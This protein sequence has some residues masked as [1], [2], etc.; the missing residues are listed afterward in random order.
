VPD[1][2]V[3]PGVA[4][5]W[6]MT[7]GEPVVRI[8]IVDGPA[9]LA[10]PALHGAAIKVLPPTWLPR[11]LQPM[12]GFPDL[13][14][15]RREHGT[16]VASVLFGRH[17]SEVPGLVPGCSGV[18]VPSLRGDAN[19]LDALNLARAI[20]AAVDAGA[21]VV[22]VELCVPSAS[23]DVDRVLRRSLEA[24]RR[25][26]VLIVAAAGNEHSRH[27]CFPA[28]VPEV[29]AVGA[30]DDDG[31][32]YRFS[33]WGPQYA[34]HGLVAPGGNMT[35]AVPGGATKVHKGT[36]CST[37][38]VAGVAGLLLSLQA[39]HGA[40]PD[41]P[42]VGRALL[43]SAAP[44]S[45]RTGD[46]Q[47]ERCMAG[48]LDVAAATELVLDGLRAGG[49][50]RSR[51]AG[52][53]RVT[54]STIAGRRIAA[55]GSAPVFALATL[56][57][58]FG[59]QARRD[60]FERFMAVSATPGAVHDER[61][62]H[63]HLLAYPSDA[64]AL[65][66]TLRLDKE[67]IYALEPAGPYAPAIYEQIVRLLGEQHAGRAERTSVAGRL[68]SGRAELLTGERGG[69]D[70]L[71]AAVADFLTRI[72]VELANR[73]RTAAQRALNFSATNAYQAADT[74]GAALA[75]GLV[76]DGIDAERSPFARADS[77]CWDVRLSFFDPENG[78]RAR[79]TTRFTIDVSDVMPVTLGEVRAWSE[80]R[81]A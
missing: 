75:R 13:A 77:D 67:P 24:A 27:S 26:G 72:H 40:R 41:P 1:V 5:L 2:G 79:R 36:S 45:V 4:E 81:A 70:A 22:A 9:D 6:E 17:D 12:P 50:L 34:D 42:G 55:D 37:P 46:E 3:I 71:R 65:T 10:H 51:R 52:S 78:R 69:G 66:W 31:R 35:G 30:H 74:L 53:G 57:Y 38:V 59:T 20:D 63:G 21:H 7:R 49:H 61:S 18:L 47:P 76:L 32:V 16:W 54:A 14:E 43:E 60:A 64:A 58:D 39:R 25:D 44:C 33:N 62:V 68:T 80:R 8:A 23:C 28:A 29:L 56:G 48:R 11:D 15:R 19:D 73:G